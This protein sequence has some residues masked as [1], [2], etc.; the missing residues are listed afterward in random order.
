[1]NLTVLEAGRGEVKRTEII[2]ECLAAVCDAWE[3]GIQI[4]P[5]EL[6]EYWRALVRDA[7]AYGHSGDCVKSSGP[8]PLCRV[9]DARR[10][11][12]RIYIAY[13]TGESSERD[14]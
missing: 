3:Y 6:P 12:D 5:H 9:E 8:C 7:V 1:M 4:E 14:R 2:S 11:A 10:D 13:E